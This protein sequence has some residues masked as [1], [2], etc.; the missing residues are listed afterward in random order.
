M[1]VFVPVRGEFLSR[2]D[3]IKEGIRVVNLSNLADTLTNDELNPAINALFIWNANLVSK[4]PNT[5]KAVEGLLRE[6][7]FTVVSE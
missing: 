7:L 4:L 5:N 2:S 6:D 1:P 3:W